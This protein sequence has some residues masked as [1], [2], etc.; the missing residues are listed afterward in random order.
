MVV[1]RVN[2]SVNCTSIKPVR[3]FEEAAEGV[4]TAI[5]VNFKAVV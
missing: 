2:N 1:D 3:E 4:R 5:P